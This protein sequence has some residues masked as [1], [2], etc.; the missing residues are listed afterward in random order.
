MLEE[1]TVV[2]D[3]LNGQRFLFDIT[4]I[5][6]ELLTEMGKALIQ[7]GMLAKCMDIHDVIS[8]TRTAQDIS[9]VI[10]L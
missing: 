3:G 10:P 8:I 6:E 9:R 7:M 4:M 2:F 1:G 5:Y